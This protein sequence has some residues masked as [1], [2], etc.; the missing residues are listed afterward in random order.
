MLYKNIF[1]ELKTQ[2]YSKNLNNLK[3]R[4]LIQRTI[5]EIDTI[6]EYLTK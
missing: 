5:Q 3:I 1:V 4:L 6:P 2:K